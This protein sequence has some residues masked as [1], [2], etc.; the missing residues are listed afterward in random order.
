MELKSVV[1]NVI[2]AVY[3]TI[4]HILKQSL[5]HTKIKQISIKTAQSISLPIYDCPTEEEL[6]LLIQTEDNDEIEIEANGDDIIN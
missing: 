6:D 1:K 2:H 4:P 5:K 3:N